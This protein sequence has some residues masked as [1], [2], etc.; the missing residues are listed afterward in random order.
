[1]IKTIIEKIQLSEAVKRPEI[2][3]ELSAWAK[4]SFPGIVIKDFPKHDRFKG[5]KNMTSGKK[6]L[7]MTA[8]IFKT[9]SDMASALEKVKK[10]RKFSEVGMKASITQNSFEVLW[11][12]FKDL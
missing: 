1:M 3:S 11:S 8:F 4:A 7:G 5:M 2:I 10:A 12:E 6:D 9:G